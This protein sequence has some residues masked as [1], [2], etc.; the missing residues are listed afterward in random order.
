MSLVR[1]GGVV[2]VVILLVVP[3]ILLAV[4]FVLV[5]LVAVLLGWRERWWDTVRS[6]SYVRD[7]KEGARRGG[8]QGP[9]ST[10]GPNLFLQQT[11]VQLQGFA[12]EHA[13]SRTLQYCRVVF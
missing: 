11:P 7:S 1:C 8:R 12:S 6:E 10:V 4:L 3:L 5:T 2:T 9:T 13:S